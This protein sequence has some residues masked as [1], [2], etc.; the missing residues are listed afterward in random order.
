MM[1]EM[2]EKAGTEDIACS[3]ELI[4]GSFFNYVN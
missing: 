1:G 4:I 2:T 3:M